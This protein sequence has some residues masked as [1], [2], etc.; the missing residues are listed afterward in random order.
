MVLVCVHR[1]DATTAPRC[2]QA[3]THPGGAVSPFRASHRAP[4]LRRDREPRT[5]L[6]QDRRGWPVELA[7]EPEAGDRSSATVLAISPQ[8]TVLSTTTLIEP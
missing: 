7:I 2:R 8:G 6:V 3:D 1:D 4:C 5:P